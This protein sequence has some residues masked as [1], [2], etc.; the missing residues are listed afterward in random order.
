MSLA[1][2]SR[3]AGVHRPRPPQRAASVIKSDA[4][5]A[6]GAR[7]PHPRTG[8]PSSR[9]PLT[10]RR[11]HMHG[12]VCAFAHTA[13]IDHENPDFPIESQNPQD[14]N[15]SSRTV[16]PIPSFGLLFDGVRSLH[17]YKQPSSRPLRPSTR[18]STQPSSRPVRRRA[19][20]LA[21]TPSCECACRWQ[22]RVVTA[23]AHR[24]RPPQRAASVIKSDARA[25][26]GARG[27]HPRTGGPS[28][29]TPLTAR[30]PFV[31]TTGENA[32][33]GH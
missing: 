7:G 6:T 29:R 28:S 9:T 27:P 11:Q 1:T 3:A 14:F 25:A 16:P 8:G 22:H 18:P 20:P 15:S 23:G 30:R 32:R 12:R 21:S 33:S 13:A 24:P 26:T 4:R 19:R 31:S 10:A 17:C 5:A 2:Q